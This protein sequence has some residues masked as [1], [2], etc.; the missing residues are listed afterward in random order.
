MITKDQLVEHL[1]ELDGPTIGKIFKALKTLHEPSDELCL[2]AAELVIKGEFKAGRSFNV[3][4]DSAL[5]FLMS[6]PWC[7]S[8]TGGTASNSEKKRMLDQNDP[9][10]NTGPILINGVFPR[11]DDVITWPIESLVFFPKNQKKRVTIF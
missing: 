6:F 7:P 4:E 10:N 8:P 9:E 3:V 2:A 5:D 11:T 1:G